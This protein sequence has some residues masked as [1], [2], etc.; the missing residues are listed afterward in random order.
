M[1]V[2][3]IKFEIND[4]ILFTMS[5]WPAYKNYIF[6]LVSPQHVPNNETQSL[7]RNRCHPIRSL[8]V[9]PNNAG[10]SFRYGTLSSE[11]L[12]SLL[13]AL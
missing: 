7:I 1:F 2:L 11:F 13:Q 5:F 9:R 6:K 10:V 12:F 3:H 8:F 4:S